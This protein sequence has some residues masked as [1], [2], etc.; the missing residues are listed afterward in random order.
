MS[1]GFDTNLL[2]QITAVSGKQSISKERVSL[3]RKPKHDDHRR[4][5]NPQKETPPDDT[6]ARSGSRGS[7]GGEEGKI[8]IT[9]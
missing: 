3:F 9:I 2:S 5:N 8:D 6:E 1:D 7:P 4:H